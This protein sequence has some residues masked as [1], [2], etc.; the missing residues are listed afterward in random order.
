MWEKLRIALA[1]LLTFLTGAFVFMW[2]DTTPPYVFDPKESFIVPEKV[3]SGTQVRVDW[4]IIKVNRFCGGINVRILFDPITKTRIAIYDPV[5]VAL[6]YDLDNSNR[7]VRTFLLPAR[8]PAGK[9]G[10]RAHQFFSCN[11][12]QKFWPLEVVTPDLFFEIVD[13]GK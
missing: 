3:E 8:I 13:G 10:Y 5:P 7:L 1:C 6:P 12:L 9:I 2:F 4:K 11:W